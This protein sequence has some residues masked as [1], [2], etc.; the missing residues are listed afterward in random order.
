MDLVIFLF[1]LEASVGAGGGQYII[2]S[3]V[4]TNDFFNI[5]MI[6]MKGL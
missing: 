5:S 4:I 6:K 2:L 1:K 3:F